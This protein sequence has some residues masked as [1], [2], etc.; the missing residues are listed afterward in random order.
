VSHVW[1]LVVIALIFAVLVF[2]IWGIAASIIEA[3]SGGGW[4]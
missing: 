4:T 3:A 1:R 2:A